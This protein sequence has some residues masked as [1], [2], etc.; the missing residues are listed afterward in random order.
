MVSQD[1]NIGGTDLLRAF[2]SNCL[3]LYKLSLPLGSNLPVSERRPGDDAAILAVMALM[4]LHKHGEFNALLR[5]AVALDFLLSHSKHNYDALLILVRLYLF[6]GAGSLAVRTYLVLSIKNIQIATLSWI[7]FTRISTTHPYLFSPATKAKNGAS[8][9][10]LLSTALDWHLS[11]ANLSDAA[12]GQMLQGRQWCTMLENIATQNSV[13]QGFCNWLA[14]VESLR[15]E[16]LAGP[17]GTGQSQLF[18][19]KSRAHIVNPVI[20]VNT[21]DSPDRIRDN[22][23]RSAFPD[24]EATG[25]LRFD[26]YLCLGPEPNVSLF[27]GPLLVDPAN[28]VF[29]E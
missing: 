10:F 19:S 20:N 22:R 4:H 13:Q 27:R 14:T 21:D 16:R 17:S 5:A 1:D 18:I 3:R 23:D 7:L 12:T 29:P 28:S 9:S 11:A 2:V 15:I 24:C 25:Q 6:L 8:A 26:R